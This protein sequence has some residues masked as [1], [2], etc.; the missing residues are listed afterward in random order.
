MNNQDVIK[1]L[2]N[3]CGV[4]VHHPFFTDKLWQKVYGFKDAYEAEILN[5]FM[6]AELS[7]KGLYYCGLGMTWGSPCNKEMCEQYL[8]K[9]EVIG[10]AYRDWCISQR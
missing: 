3:L 1:I 10:K 4:F 9:F 7:N 6:I 2:I 5:Y 8:S